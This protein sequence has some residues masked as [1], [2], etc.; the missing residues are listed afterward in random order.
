MWEGIGIVLA[1]IITAVS[2]IW[3]NYRS[4]AQT[5]QVAKKLEASNLQISTALVQSDTKINGKLNEIHTLTNDRLHKIEMA[6]ME[7][8]NNLQQAR[9]T[10]VSLEAKLLEF[11]QERHRDDQEQKDKP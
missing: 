9:Q 2:V 10:V 8:L 11:A 7:A 6:L 4:T 5:T 1:A 3:A